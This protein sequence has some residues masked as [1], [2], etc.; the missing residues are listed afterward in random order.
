M[1]TDFEIESAFQIKDRHFYIL[2]KLL[3]G[4][5]KEGMSADFSPIGIKKKIV[6]ESVDFSLNKDDKGNYFENIGLGF[7]SFTDDEKQFLIANSPFD[8]SISVE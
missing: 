3:S 2:G 7:S 6:I 8:R 4:K 5:I 1:S